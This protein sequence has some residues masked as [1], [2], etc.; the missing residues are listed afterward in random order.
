MFTCAKILKLYINTENVLYLL[1]TGYRQE[2]FPLYLYVSFNR[3]LSFYTAHNIYYNILI[4]SYILDW[5][6]YNRQFQL[7][8]YARRGWWEVSYP[9]SD[10]AEKFQ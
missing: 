7:L 2:Y 1:N 9:I 4:Y 3:R 5:S 8:I 10:Y 6:N